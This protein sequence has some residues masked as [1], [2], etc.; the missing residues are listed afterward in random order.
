MTR[1]NI[2]YMHSHD[3]GRYIQPYG[4]AVATP[5]LQ[6]LAEQG[7]LFRQAFCAGPTCS[8]SRAALL[9]G[10]SPHSSGMI[11]L[12]HRGF[13]LKDYNQHIVHMLR[14][15]GYETT[16]CGVHHEAKDVKQ[17]GYGRVIAMPNRNAHTVAQEAV[18][19]LSESPRQPFFLAVGCGETHRAYPPPCPEEDPR[20]K[21]P[22][23][24]LPDAPETRYDVAGFNT[25]ARAMDRAWGQVLAALDSTG[26]AANTLVICTTDHGIAFPGMKCNLTDHGIG[27]MLIVRG[28][29]GFDGGKAV[30][31]M[32]SHIDVFPTIC[33]LLEIPAPAWLEGK[34]I[35]PLVRGQAEQIN[36]EIFSEVTYHAAYE[37]MRCIR[38]AR[39]KYIRRFGDR[40][41]PVLANCD[42]SP[43]KDL[44]MR[45]HWRDRPVPQEELYDLV[46]D[47]NESCNLAGDEA[48]AKELA[49]LRRRLEQWMTRTNDPLLAG[50]VAPP[51]GA[52]VSDSDDVSPR[53]VDRRGGRKG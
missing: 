37:P 26:L 41:R 19:F 35:L 34:S 49:E 12:A 21:R 27:V 11:G 50:F 15:A 51:P 48:R 31:A 16:L 33:E 40:R 46:F 10:Q 25:L 29:G 22:P 42:D 9:T 17:I 53:D 30:D 14:E 7:T 6:K 8:P 45:H 3:T 5:N 13:R 18:K 32:V 1:P 47:P 28:P 39:Y 24:P 23:A 4:H 38:T 44:W 43:S 52:I 2:L 36:E 20:H